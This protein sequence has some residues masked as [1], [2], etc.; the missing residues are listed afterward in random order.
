VLLVGAIAVAALALTVQ[1]VERDR[2]RELL[3]QRAQEAATALGAVLPIFQLP[4]SSALA[5]AEETGGSA[6]SFERVVGGFLA[7]GQLVS[8]ASLWRVA[9][10]G[11][12]LPTV[13][14]GRPS[15]LGAL[16]PVDRGRILDGAPA[17]QL[18]IIDLTGRPVRALG[19]ALA[20]GPDGSGVR[21]V[22][23]LEVRLPADPTEIDLTGDAFDDLDYAVYLND[24]RR[25]TSVLSAT[26]TDLPL[27]RSAE[28]VEVPWGTA[29]MQLVFVPKDDLGGGLLSR[30]PWLILGLG[31]VL[32]VAFAWLAHR[33]QAAT[34]ASA[35]LADRNEELF[36]EQRTLAR[37]L[38]R[39][40]LPA[41]L[42]LAPSIQL[43]HE[44]Q[45]GVAGMDIGGDWYDAVL[46]DDD[47]QLLFTV[48][49]VSGQGLPAATIMISLRMAIR[50]WASEGD[51]PAAILRKVNRLLDVRADGHFATIVCGCL[52]LRDGRLRLVSAGHPPPVVLEPD[53]P[54]RLLQAPVGLPVGVG[55][56]PYE[57]LEVVLA[58]GT[59]LVAF[60]DG[61]YER[62]GEVV[63]D[64]MERVRAELEAGRHLPLAE[65]VARLTSELAAADAPDDTA[66]LAVTFVGTP[67]LRGGSP[68]A[69]FG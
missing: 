55:A 36:V 61:L 15:Q 56:D 5:V 63:D 8:S 60:T 40:L 17:G 6:A 33:L 4:L 52:D 25:P 7:P 23:Y 27:P 9:P 59:T 21:T 62:R 22:A 58:P 12:P 47:Q 29:T 32:V 31:G 42:P 46:I 13:V 49:D 48:G 10:E 54:A 45:S 16:E 35:A 50:A 34:A 64:G 20:S 14:L 69:A 2:E 66:V 11:T 1:S 38:Q 43:A 30:L 19:I 53:R 68:A 44:Y 39:D 41:A 28:Q 26:T 65:L 37:T 57:A 3:R 67:A 18:D 24:A 51:D